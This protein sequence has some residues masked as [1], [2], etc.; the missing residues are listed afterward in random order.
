MTPSKAYFQII[1]YCNFGCRGCPS[2]N[3][4]ESLSTLACKDI[5]DDI[6][7]AGMDEIVFTGGEPL[8]RDDIAELIS[9]CRFRDLELILETNA[10]LINEKTAE[11]L[12]DSRISEAIINVDGSRSREHDAARNTEGGFTKALTGYQTLRS[13][14]IESSFNTLIASH[15]INELK[16][17]LDLVDRLN[18][19]SI[20]FYTQLAGGTCNE[21]EM[22]QTISPKK[23]VST[24][25]WLSEISLK[26]NS[27]INL[28]CAP[29]YLNVIEDLKEYPDFNIEPCSVAQD[30]L[31]IDYKGDIF[32]C[33]HFEE[34]LGNTLDS[35]LEDIWRDSDLIDQ[36]N[37]GNKI[38]GYCGNCSLISHCKGCRALAKKESGDYLE[39]DPTCPLSFEIECSETDVISP[40]T[41]KI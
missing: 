39:Q 15:N 25:K 18:P 12:K 17:L 24:V 28:K 41:P 19:D 27:T 13:L 11:Q 3:R 10:T 6:S 31:V 21:L 20:N 34:P 36:L 35:T 23:M 26:K 30:F 9:Y 4:R 16:N 2:G 22:D 38:K 1:G 5:I 29:G 37:G 33:S 32:P 14:G 40:L 8:L 7:T